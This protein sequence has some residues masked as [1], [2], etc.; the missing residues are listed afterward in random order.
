VIESLFL[1]LYFSYLILYK[2]FLA[3][4]KLLYFY[5]KTLFLPLKMDYFLV[6]TKE[7]SNFATQMVRK[8]LPMFTIKE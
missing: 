7:L 4:A 8:R 5:K 3:S 1:Y 6:I 2:L